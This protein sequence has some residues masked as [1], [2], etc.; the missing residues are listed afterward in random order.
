MRARRVHAPVSDNATPRSCTAWE[1]ADCFL[2]QQGRHWHE[3]A[4]NR[5][6]LDP[7]H[8]R[9]PIAGGAST[10]ALVI[11]A[12]RAGG[13][14][15]LAAGYKAPQTLADQV[16]TVRAAGGHSGTLTPLEVPPCQ[17]RRSGDYC[18]AGAPC[19]GGRVGW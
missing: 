10:P 7:S 15:F 12:A 5:S 17:G 16:A 4:R 19:R 8:H 18:L 1:G 2:S 11:A 9:G 3:H 6:R 13:L 14:G